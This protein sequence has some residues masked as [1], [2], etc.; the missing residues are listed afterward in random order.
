[1]TELLQKETDWSDVVHRP[2]SSVVQRLK[3]Q[4][5][6]VIALRPGELSEIVLRRQSIVITLIAQN[7]E[8]GSIHVFDTMNH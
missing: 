7:N 8:V 1:M 4:G 5:W 3:S 2:L 6:R